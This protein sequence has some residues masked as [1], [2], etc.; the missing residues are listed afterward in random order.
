VRD[1]KELQHFRDYIE[2][3]PSK[4]GLHENGFILQVNRVLQMNHQ[5][6]GET[7]DGPTGKMPVLPAALLRAKKLGFSDRQLA[8]AGGVPEKAIRSQRIAQ[9]VTPTYRLVDTCAAEFEA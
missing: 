5:A 3:N 1:E 4:A 8:I 2:C 9:N 7:P 6:S